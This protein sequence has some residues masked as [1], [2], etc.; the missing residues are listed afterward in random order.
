MNSNPDPRAPRVEILCVGTELLGGRA[1][2]H[3]PYLA[4]RLRAAGF[5]VGRASQLPDDAGEIAGAL[6]EAL[7]RSEGVILCGGLGPTFDDVTREGAAKALKR[8]LLFD[9][10]LFREIARKLGRHGFAIPESNRRQ[11]FLLEGASAL[12][13]RYGSA[14]A[15]RVVLGGSR[16]PKLV[17]LLPG[18]P[19]ELAPIFER[20]VLPDLKR[21]LARGLSVESFALHLI[22]LA[23]SKAEELLRPVIELKRPWLDFTIL[24]SD[25]EIEFHAVMAGPSR[26][27]NRELKTRL[28]RQARVLAG[29]HLFGMGEDSLEKAVGRALRRRGLTLALA[30]SC[31]AGILSARLTQVPG[32]SRYFLGGYLAYSN[33]LKRRLLGVKAETLRRWGA[34]SAECAGEMARLAR[35]RCRSSVG[36]SITGIAGPA[37]GTRDKPVGTVFFGLSGPWSAKTEAFERHFAGDRETIRR[38]AASFALQ[39]LLRAIA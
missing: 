30:E 13:N 20:Q 7:R 32:S 22:G 17:Y 2:G 16:R 10:G 5:L 35:R 6:R 23:E 31:T 37:G 12:A 3:A 14:P 39:Q 4:K 38:R 36:L 21:R 33:G 15:Q 9:P 26:S 18:P 25:G 28:L 27:Q 29:R 11:A 24:A 34:V 1:D 19:R 8:R